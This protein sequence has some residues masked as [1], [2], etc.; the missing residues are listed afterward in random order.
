[1]SVKL[2]IIMS[3]NVSY[4]VDMDFPTYRNAKGWF[5]KGAEHV[6]TDGGSGAANFMVIPV[7]G[8]HVMINPFRIMAIEFEEME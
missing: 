6:A 1:M 5:L 7:N 3:D 4:K 8:G 2:S